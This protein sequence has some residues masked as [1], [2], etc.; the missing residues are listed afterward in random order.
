MKFCYTFYRDI[1]NL[2][3]FKN[4]HHVAVKLIEMIIIETRKYL[5]TIFIAEKKEKDFLLLVPPRHLYRS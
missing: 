4:Y 3:S 1:P 5:F 2:N